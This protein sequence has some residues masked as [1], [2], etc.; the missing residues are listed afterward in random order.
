MRF[1]LETPSRR[2]VARASRERPLNFAAIIL[3]SVPIAARVSRRCARGDERMHASVYAIGRIGLGIVR[4]SRA[5]VCTYTH[6]SPTRREPSE[7]DSASSPF[8]INYIR[9]A[10]SQSFGKML[11]RDDSL[12][13][14]AP[15]AAALDKISGRLQEVGARIARLRRIIYKLRSAPG[16]GGRA[17]VCL[18]SKSIICRVLRDRLFCRYSIAPLLLLSRGIRIFEVNA[19]PA[20]RSSKR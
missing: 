7:I 6:G 8:F 14:A 16:P 1:V 15:F 2:E 18:E 5:H 17:R 19:R 3:S 10:R 13:R 4:L 20:D 11:S 9:E 12:R